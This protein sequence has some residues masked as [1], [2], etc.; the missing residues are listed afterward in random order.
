MVGSLLDMA[1]DD[2]D[3]DAPL[4]ILKALDARIVDL[5]GAMDDIG[6]M[7]VTS[8]LQRFEDQ[9]DP[10][11]LSW[12]KSARAEAE[13][14]QTLTDRGHL[15]HSITHRADR[16]SVQ[17]GTNVVYGA[18]HQFGGVIQRGNVIITMPKRSY[19][20]LPSEDAHAAESIV[21]DHLQAVIGGAR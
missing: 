4:A 18:I 11:G 6:G 21:V 13:N 17:V 20:G 19:L 12:L 5:S 10:D 1:V 2:L 14:G 3:I 9:T 7:L 8:T 15:R 16:Y